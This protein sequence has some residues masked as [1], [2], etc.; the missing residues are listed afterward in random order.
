MKVYLFS[1][2]NQ[3]LLTTVNFGETL[4]FLTV[5]KYRAQIASICRKH[6]FKICK[7]PYLFIV[8]KQRLAV[9]HWT[10]ELWRCQLFV[11]PTSQNYISG[12]A[13]ACRTITYSTFYNIIQYKTRWWKRRQIINFKS[14]RSK[15]R[16]TI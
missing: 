14:M 15:G 13:R 1:I 12:S 7:S 6:K 10:F 2:I 3:S 8:R 9:L 4:L 16:K 5:P 11:R